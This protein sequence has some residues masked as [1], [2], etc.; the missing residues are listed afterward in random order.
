MDKIYNRIFIMAV[1]F[2]GLLFM[3]VMPVSAVSFDEWL[4]F[5]LEWTSAVWFILVLVVCVAG[6]SAGIAAKHYQSKNWTW[7]PEDVVYY[8]LV[9]SASVLFFI[10]QTPLDLCFIYSASLNGGLGILRN[11]V[12]ERQEKKS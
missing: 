3:L 8:M 5:P 10:S 2:I 4:P 9:A 6:G 1:V 7:H 11:L 12:T